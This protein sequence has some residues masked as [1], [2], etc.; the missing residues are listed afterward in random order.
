MELQVS[1]AQAIQTTRILAMKRN[2]STSF[3]ILL[4][5]VLN[6]FG[7]SHATVRSK[8]MKT[9]QL[10]IAADPTILSN[11]SISLETDHD[12]RSS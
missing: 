8:A 5:H 2:L 7:E 9:L 1:R 3:N 6:V 4:K 11:V 10:I 12:K